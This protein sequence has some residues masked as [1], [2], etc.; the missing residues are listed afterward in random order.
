MGPQTGHNG[1]KEEN[2]WI[3]YY[4]KG[5]EG[6]LQSSQVNKTLMSFRV[7]A[8]SLLIAT[9]ISGHFWTVYP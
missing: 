3:P 5:G 7:T 1:D 6:M 2:P 4:E 9:G 8:F